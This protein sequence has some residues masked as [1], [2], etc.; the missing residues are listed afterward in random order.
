MQYDD[1]DKAKFTSSLEHGPKK[2]QF[3][4]DVFNM[5]FNHNQNENKKEIEAYLENETKNEKFFFVTENDQQ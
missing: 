1:D 5:S 3:W 2:N 4:N